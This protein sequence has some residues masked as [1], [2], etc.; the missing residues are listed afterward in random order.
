MGA[1][2]FTGGQVED[3]LRRQVIDLKAKLA[4]K[5]AEIERLLNECRRWRGKVLGIHKMNWLDDGTTPDEPEMIPM[6]KATLRN[7][8]EH[9]GSLEAKLEKCRK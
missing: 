1:D 8:N 7:L 6:H 5:D 9:I 3:R 4:E 2:Y